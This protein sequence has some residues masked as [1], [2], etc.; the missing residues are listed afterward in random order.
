MQEETDF[1]T[2][3]ASSRPRHNFQGTGAQKFVHFQIEDQTLALKVD[4]SE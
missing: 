4:T 1:I 2:C 3:K